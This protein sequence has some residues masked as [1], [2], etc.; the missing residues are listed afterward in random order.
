MD[1]YELKRKIEDLK[2]LVLSQ[3]PRKLATIALAAVLI[4]VSGYVA[5]RTVAW[6][7]FSGRPGI[8]SSQKEQAREAMESPEAKAD[9]EALAKLKF[10]EIQSEH[11]KRLKRLNDLEKKGEAESEE[12]IQASGALL[13]SYTILQQRQREQGKPGDDR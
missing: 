6:S 1:S 13:R 12:G 5:L 10:A 7:L 3:P 2:H 8:S 9:L 4:P 11:D